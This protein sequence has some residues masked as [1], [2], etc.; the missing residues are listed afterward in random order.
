MY[1]RTVNETEDSKQFREVRAPENEHS[2]LLRRLYRRSNR[3]YKKQLG[4]LDHAS[5]RGYPLG[6]LAF[7]DEIVLTN[8]ADISV[9]YWS[10]EIP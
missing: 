2:L 9:G 6:L 3:V 1:L 10:K 4:M 5:L 8:Q 7:A